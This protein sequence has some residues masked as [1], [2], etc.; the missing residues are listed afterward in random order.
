[1][2]RA[3]LAFVVAV[4]ACGGGEA[5]PESTAGDQ[6]GTSPSTGAATT[7]TI[8]VTTTE[9]AVPPAVVRLSSGRG[10]DGSFEV[11]VWFASDPFATGDHR[12]V[13]GAD[14]DLSYPGVGDPYPFLNGHLEL[15]P[16]GATLGL[17]DDV[18]AEGDAAAE[19]VSWG[20][21]DG[22]LRVFFI[23]TTPARGGTTWVIVEVGGERVE[24]GTAGAPFGTSCSAHSAGIG[25]EIPAGVPDA[26]EP[27]R[28]P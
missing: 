12:I 10:D 15:T 27:C 26:G 16:E 20:F 1:M 4:A 5:V 19:R 13:V 21:A 22:A 23:D 18:I 11:T 2:R 3:V 17:A 28:Y 7:T 8:A 9:A 6:V 14:V 24:F 25:V